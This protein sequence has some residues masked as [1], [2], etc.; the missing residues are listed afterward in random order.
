[1]LRRISAF[2]L[3]TASL[4]SSGN[5]V[6]ADK[7]IVS[8]WGYVYTIGYRPALVPSGV[9]FDSWNDLWKP[10]LKGMVALPDWDP[11]HIIA[12][13]AKPSGADAV[14]WQQGQAKLKALLR[15]QRL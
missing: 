12:V 8:T 6:A 15:Q 2:T 5:T 4:V 14:Q 1:M 11:S 13:T 7:S 3:L 9:T 10:E